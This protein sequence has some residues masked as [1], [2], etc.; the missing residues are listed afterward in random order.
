[1]SML[2]KNL[3]TLR[4]ERELTQQDMGDYLGMSRVG[5][6]KYEKGTAEPSL[7]TLIKLADLYNTTIDKLVGRETFMD[8]VHM[9]EIQLQRNIRIEV[10]SQSEKIVKDFLRENEDIIINRV[11]DALIK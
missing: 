5:Y 6:F 2:S 9:K 8:S 4:E 3:K 10:K 1:M 11:K 7:E